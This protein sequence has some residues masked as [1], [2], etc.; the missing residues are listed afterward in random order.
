MSR[1]D[2]RASASARAHPA[3]R[4][5]S[6]VH[7]EVGTEAVGTMEKASRFGL[8]DRQTGGVRSRTEI[9]VTKKETWAAASM[10]VA[11]MVL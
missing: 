2:E 3:R 9:C 6:V 10:A 7:Q 5:E 8:F 11:D 1:R 4:N